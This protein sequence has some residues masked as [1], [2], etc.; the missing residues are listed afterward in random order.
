MKRKLA[1]LLLAWAALPV[2][3]QGQDGGG[4]PGM[5]AEAPAPTITLAARSIGSRRGDPPERRAHAAL[6]VRLGPKGSG[7]IVQG[8]K[9]AVAGWLPGRARVVGYVIP[10]PDPDVEFTRAAGAFWGE[11]G[12]RDLPT[13]EIATFVE[14]GL[15]EARLRA[16]VDALNEEFRT[17]DYRLEGG[18]SSNSFVSRFLERLGRALPDVGDA[19]LPG[20]GWHG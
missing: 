1:I 15:T 10:C 5:R 19:D 18:P 9:E 8:G 16:I 20:W 11:P 6:L 13:R 14:P 7:F 12:V 17:R 2:P 4:V 3:A